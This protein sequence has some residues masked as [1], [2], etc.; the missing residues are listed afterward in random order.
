L[1]AAV[2]LKQPAP[3]L[4][5]ALHSAALA[6]GAAPSELTRAH[7]LALSALVVDYHGQGPVFLPGGIHVTRKY[8]RLEALVNNE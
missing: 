3:I 4:H 1:D 5:G 2:L 8:G 7:V 6:W